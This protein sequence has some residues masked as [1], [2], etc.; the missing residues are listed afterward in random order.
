MFTSLP[1]ALF[2]HY[3]ASLV[4]QSLSLS[5]ISDNTLLCIIPLFFTEY[6]LSMYPVFVS[7][8]ARSACR[9]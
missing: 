5:L 9:R 6:L 8:M 4:L 3:R 2:A 7:V 1:R